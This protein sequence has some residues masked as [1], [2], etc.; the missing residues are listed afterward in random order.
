[1]RLSQIQSEGV[2]RELLGLIKQFAFAFREVTLNSGAKSSFYVDCKQVSMRSDGAFALGR[3]FFDGLTHIEKTT[4][5]HFDACG[6]MA[7]GALPLSMALT[8]TAFSQHRN[9]PSISVRKEAKDHGTKSLI[10][11]PLDSLQNA[12]ILLVEDVVTTGKASIQAAKTLRDAGYVVEHVLA[13][14][15]REA[16][17]EA[18]L[19]EQGLA[20]HTLFD[21]KDLGVRT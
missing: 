18:S 19:A 13:M 21:L 20:L 6:G 5:A 15:D 14:I 17:G 7:M 2:R 9:L 8:L 3:V 16:G 12:R 11:G 1:M 4:G 10:E